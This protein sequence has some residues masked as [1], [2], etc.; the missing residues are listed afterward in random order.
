MPLAKGICSEGCASIHRGELGTLETIRRARESELPR[1][2]LNPVEG[3][4]PNE[5][6]P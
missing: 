2:G 1:D 6:G 3:V 4:Q 5:V